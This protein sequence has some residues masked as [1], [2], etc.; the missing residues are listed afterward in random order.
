MD[1]ERKPL[2]PKHKIITKQVN[3]ALKS[4]N[5]SINNKAFCHVYWS[6]W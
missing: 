1:N 4:V 5:E 2:I 3:V 6:E